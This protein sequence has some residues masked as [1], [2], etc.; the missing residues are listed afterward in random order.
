M[1]GF[2]ERHL[3]VNGADTAVLTAGEGEPLV[4]FHGGGVVEGFDCFLPLAERFRFIAPYHP[5]FGSSA[6]DPSVASMQDWVRRS[7]ELLD[8]LGLE[9]VVLAGHSLGAWLAA[10]FAIDHP[11]RVRRLVVASAAGLDVPNH[12]IANLGAIPPEQVYTLL[13]ND[14][15]IFDG[16]VQLPLDDAFL[17][18]RAREGRS[19]G[20]VVPGPFDPIL[21]ERLGSVRVPTLILWGDDDRIVPVEHAPFWE[22]ALPDARLRIFSGRGHL[23]FHETPEAVEAVAAFAG[24]P[25]AS[26]AL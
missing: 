20:Q 24:E 14:P 26:T 9:T 23:L 16:L 2:D 3:T 4:F 5:G 13:T 7:V 8:L 15:S 17:A 12:P 1:P 25:D 18:A 19:L 10:R 21:V 22:A 11:E 6:D